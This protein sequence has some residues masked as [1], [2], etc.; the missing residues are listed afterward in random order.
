MLTLG[1]HKSIKIKQLLES[2]PSNGVRAVSALKQLGYSQDLLNRY[3][4]SGWL[5]SL[6]DGALMRPQDEPTLLGAFYAL[7]HDLNL[8]VHIG[9]KSALE[10]RGRGH[11]V[12]Q[13][14]QV[15]W[16]FG[17]VRRLPTWFFNYKWKEKIHLI[18]EKFLDFHKLDGLVSFDQA[19]KEVLVS[20][21]VR[22]MLELLSLVPKNQSFDEAKELM[23]GLTNSNP[24]EVAK[25]LKSC[26]SVKA[27][28]LFM[29]L[30][31]VC[32]HQ[33]ASMVDQSQ[34]DFGKGVRQIVPGG[35]LNK[36]YQIVVPAS[37]FH[38]EG[39]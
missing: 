7:Q 22:A 17:E 11:Y 35:K 36:K 9:G 33:W 34:I 6:G 14:K 1:K 10:L 24:K 5:K 19:N 39:T 16:I 13:G 37:I 12:R 29:L 26:K 20:N 8:N 27:K 38:T 28:R 4:Y 3:R 30:S 2:W 15:V 32:G 21:D 25:L 23:S 18:G 31:E